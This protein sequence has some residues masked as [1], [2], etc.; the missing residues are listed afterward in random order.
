MVVTGIG[1]ISSLGLNR[2][3]FW[4]ALCEG[5]SGI[6]PIKSVDCTDLPFK[7]AAEVS[8]FNPLEHFAEKRIHFLDRFAQFAL[9]TTREA[10]LDSKVELKGHANQ[11][12][13]IITGSCYGGLISEDQM[14][15]KL[16]RQNRSRVNP[17]AIPRIMASAGASLISIEFGITGPTFTLSTACSSSAH[18]IGLAFWM[19][20]QG[21]AEMAITGGSEAPFSFGNLKAWQAM[22]V[23]SPDTCRPFSKNRSGM[24][25][26]EG[27]AM[28]ILEPLDTALLR[29][30]RIYAEIVGFGMSADAYH[31]TDPDTMGEARAMRAS[32]EDSGVK[33]QQIGYINA[34]GT[35][36]RSNDK[37]ETLAIRS[38]FGQHI[39]KLAISST[40]SAHGHTLGAAGA[41]ES[42]AT[43][44]A[45]YHGILPPT[46]NFI[47][48]DP[49]CDLDV[50]PNKA[51][52]IEVEY[53]LSNSFSFG[54]LNVVLV[55][56]RWDGCA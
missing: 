44:L 7:N 31:L 56:R 19:I 24:I 42:A 21:I 27:G 36:T 55:F 33:I 48:P 40:K 32:L 47:E 39:K 15:F 52:Q 53:A 4:Q 12:I 22:R 2:F 10:L 13:A 45:L 9:V 46:V 3:Q 50:V 29:G 11:Q 18:A 20:R 8:G 5:R 30:A 49:E 54:G 35:G 34:H 38:V 14:F 6:A 43:I 37:T 16:Y 41:M 17:L 28:M 23:V 25:L 1:V 26:G 51:R